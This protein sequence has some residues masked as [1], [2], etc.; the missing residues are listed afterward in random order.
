VPGESFLEIL[1]AAEDHQ[2]MS[3]VSSRHESGAA[4]MAGA[5]AKLSEVPAVAMATRG[6]GASNLAIGVH[7]AHQDSTPMLVLLGQ[8][9]SSSLGREAF[10]E[11]D[12]TA[13][14]SPVTKWAATVPRADRLPEFVARGLRI[15]TSSRPGPVMFAIPSDLLGE[16]IPEQLVGDAAAPPPLRL[17]P[18]PAEARSVARRLAEARNP[19]LISGG[20]AYGAREALIAFAETFSLGV[21]TAFRRQD[22][23]PNEHPQY[24]GHLTLGTPPENLEAMEQADLVLVVG[25][26]LSEVTTQ[27]YRLPKAGCAVIQIDIDPEEIGAVVPVERGIVADARTALTAIVEQVSSPPARAWSAA[28]QAYLESSSIPPGRT[29]TGIDPA[30]VISAMRQVLPEDATMANDAGNFSTFLHRY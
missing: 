1:D 29:K 19:V 25:C 30:Q 7:T 11:V 20:G 22:T 5:D 3:L 14:Y 28:H 6:V 8:V 21:Y 24:L 12:L 26:R 4:F 2:E 10:Q 9:E 13:F 23:F 15:A 27:G 18:D 17:A 16:D